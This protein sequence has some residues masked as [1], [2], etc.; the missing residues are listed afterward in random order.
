MKSLLILKGQSQYNLLRYWTDALAIGFEKQG[1]EVTI[2]DLKF[3][4]NHILSKYLNEHYDA[5]L[6]FNGYMLAPG[7]STS[8]N[9]PYIYLLIDHPIDHINRINNLKSTDI[10]TI[11]D[12]YDIHTVDRFCKMP[13]YVYMLPHAA[14]EVNMIKSKKEIDVLFTGTYINPEN[15]KEKWKENEI[16]YRIFEDVVEKCLYNTDYYYIEEVENWMREEY[17]SQIDFKHNNFTALIRDIGYYIYSYRRLKVLDTILK[18]G[19][20]IHIYGEKWDSSPLV[21]YK[22][23]VLHEG[24]NYWQLQEVMRKSKIVMNIAGIAKDG[25]HERVFAAMSAQ[26]VLLTNETPYLRELF[27]ENEE[28][29]FYSFNHIEE[30]PM[31]IKNLLVNETEINRISKNALQAIIGNHTWNERAKQ[32]IEIFEDSNSKK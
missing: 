28:L 20:E 17:K 24:V 5:V 32:I 21:K 6:G 27:K 7:F 9:C 16:L 10:L 18:A 8:L 23:A 3:I 30:V 31:K 1:V 11:V 25:T 15:Y 12:R 19:I 26:S 14:Q 4:D 2:L 22:N 29:V 13:N